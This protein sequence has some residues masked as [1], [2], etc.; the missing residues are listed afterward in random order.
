VVYVLSEGEG[1]GALKGDSQPA[2]RGI[3]VCF[4]NEK[5]TTHTPYFTG[6]AEFLNRGAIAVH[7]GNTVDRI[8]DDKK[9]RQSD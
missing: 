6:G 2:T 9:N 3:F 4:S 8:C 1:L 5:S 7:T